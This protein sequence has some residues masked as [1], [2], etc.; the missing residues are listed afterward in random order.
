MDLDRFKNINDSLGHAMGDRVLRASAGRI[1]QAVGPEHTAARISGDEFAAILVDIGSDAQAD[2]VARRVLAAFDPPL[3]LDDRHDVTISPSIGISLYPEHAQVPSELL[4]QADTAMYRAKSAGRRTVQVYSPDM[5]A[6]ARHRATLASTLR[7]IRMDEELAMVYQPRYSLAHSRI[8]GAEALMRW[9]SR[10]FGIVAPDQFIPLAEETGVILEMGEW[11]LRQSC[12]ALKR[13]QR[14]GMEGLRM[15]VNVSALQL[16]RGNLPEVLDRL[17]A[18]TGVRGQDLELE[19]TETV[20]MNDVGRNADTL[21]A[22]RQ[23]GVHLAIDD[24]GTGYSSLAYL[25]RLPIN[26]L[27]IDQEF[28][29]DLTRD[30]DDEAITSTIIAMGHSLGLEVVAEGVENAGQ[31]RFLRGHG[32]DEI[33]GFLL[34][35]PLQADACL[36]F[37]RLPVHLP[38]SA[39]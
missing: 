28:I 16:Q 11:A 37:M 14:Q 32:C 19:L 30:A 9:H 31:L 3:P 6:H 1:Q 23:L 26:T 8:V 34:S 35:P 5:D 25:K 12:L 36:D 4:R 27:K 7:G 22:C 2:A 18:E 21:H 13:W 20:V 15:S 33:Q 17:L 29:A 10:Q 38:P 39:S 24:F